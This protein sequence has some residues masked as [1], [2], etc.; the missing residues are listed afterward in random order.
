MMD[1]T[2]ALHASPMLVQQS[3]LFSALPTDLLEEMT[4]YFRAEEWPKGKLFDP[5][6]LMTRFYILIDGQLE[7]KRHNPENGREL[8][9]DL[10]KPGD[11]FDVIT[12]LDGKPHELIVSPLSPLKLI[13]APIEVVRSW[14]WKYSE[15]N[16]Q[17]LP[18][19]AAKMREQ[20]DL[21]TSLA[22]HNITT[23]LSRLILKHIG[24]IKSY[25]G[26]KDQEHRF[27]LI[28]GLS[29]EVLAR[30]VGSVRQVVNK[31]LQHWKQEGVL[32]KKRNQLLINDLEA[33]REEA[34]VIERKFLT[35]SR[36]Q[37]D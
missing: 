6:Q 24:K 35:G 5:E 33:L 16:R 1:T 22:L 29:D 32:D 27:H 14:L 18:Y 20:E 15:L 36:Q 9:L 37:R 12:L 19:L 13:H 26:A 30:M 34:G 8:T 11:S 28:S 2:R 17:F 3:R 31:Q 21:A 23:R 7:L 25:T 10:L 4:R